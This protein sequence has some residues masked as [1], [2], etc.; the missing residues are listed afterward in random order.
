MPKTRLLFEGRIRDNSYDNL[1]FGLP[2]LDSTD[3]QFLLGATWQRTYKTTGFFKVGYIQKNFDSDLRDDDSGLT[4][5]SGIDWKPKT[6]STVHLETT[7]TFNETNG[8]G[9][10]IDA[11]YYLLNWKHAWKTRFTTN[12]NLAYQNQTFNNDPRDD[13]YYQAGI[14]AN[15]DFRRWLSISAGYRYLNLNSTDDTFDYDQNIFEITAD[16]TF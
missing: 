10:S 7:K 12:I 11:S 14:S 1:V 5:Q 4:W 16:F 8:D 3:T 6:Y 15:Y 9:D 2:S 13:D